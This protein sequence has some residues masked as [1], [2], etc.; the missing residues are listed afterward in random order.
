M[1]KKLMMPA[2]LIAL[3]SSFGAQAQCDI[4]DLPCW[5]PDKKCNIKFRNETGEASGS[6]G[7][8][9]NQASYV[10]TAVVSARKRDG[11]LAGSNKLE[12]LAGA[13]KTMNLDKKKGFSEI[14]IRVKP[15]AMNID[16]TVGMTCGHIRETLQGSGTC[17]IFMVKYSVYPDQYYVA[18]N[19]NGGKV[20]S[21][22]SANAE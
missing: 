21:R 14:N 7:S 4:T 9:Y 10:K 20:M 17:K 19:C 5:G 3:L 13:N 2:A 8:G 1:L 12:I 16:E 6:G 11:S 22:K 18:Y 15:K